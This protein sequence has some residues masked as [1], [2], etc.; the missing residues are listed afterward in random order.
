MALQARRPQK[1]A[2]IQVIGAGLGRTGTNSFCAAVEALLK[3]PAYHVS[4][5]MGKRLLLST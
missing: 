2:T 3:G 1:G 4:K 5:L